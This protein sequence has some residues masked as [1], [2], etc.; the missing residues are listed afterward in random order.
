AARIASEQLYDN[1]K[2][3]IQLEK[4]LTSILKDKF[5]DNISFNSDHKNKIPGLVNVRFIG[6]NNQILLK[7]LSPIIAASSGSA[8]SSTQPSHVLQAIGL[9]LTATRESVSFLYLQYNTLDEVDVFM[10]L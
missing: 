1:Q 7:K 2:K 4:K 5:D 6:I 9:Q 3:L 10:E 8:C